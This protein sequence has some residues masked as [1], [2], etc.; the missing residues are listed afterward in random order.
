MNIGCDTIITAVTVG[1]SRISNDTLT[2]GGPTVSL[3]RPVQGLDGVYALS[4]YL[5]NF[6]STWKC[7][8][9]N[10]QLTQC[11]VSNLAVKACSRDI[12]GLIAPSG[13]GFTVSFNG[14]RHGFNIR[15]SFIADISHTVTPT[16][17][18]LLLTGE[19]INGS[20]L[21]T[22]DIG[23]VLILF[24]CSPFSVQNLTVMMFH[25]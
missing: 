22:V 1:G 17:A 7:G 15:S 9:L 24:I 19:F 25:L 10:E 23:R 18:P 4:T 6:N 12:I 3:W 11:I 8:Q 2:G 16:Q 13:T 20:P 5:T 21:V 14:G